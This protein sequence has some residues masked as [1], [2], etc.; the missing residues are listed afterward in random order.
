MAWA[1]VTG[2]PEEWA[3]GDDDLL[4]SLGCGQP[5]Q[6][7]KRTEEG[8]ACGEDADTRYSGADFAPG[9]QRCAEA[10]T[11]VTGVDLGGDLVCAAPEPDLGDLPG[12]LDGVED[13]LD[14]L[15][16]I[17]CDGRDCGEDGCGGSCGDCAAWEECRGGR[18]EPAVAVRQGWVLVPPGT[19]TMGSP[20]GEPGRDEDETQHQ[21]T[22]TRAF[23]LK[24]TEVTQGEWRALMGGN[25]S[26]FSACGDRCP[27]EQ[28]SRADAAGFCNAL[29]RAHGLEE[30]YQVDGDDIGWPDGLDCEGYRLPT[31]AEWEYA[32]RAGAEGAVPGE[33]P[34]VI[35][36]EAHAEA[37]HPLGWYAGNS[38]VTHA[39]GEDCS[40]WAET[41]HPATSCGTHPVALK[42]PNAWGLYDVVGNVWEWVWDL[43][44]PYAGDAV[45]PTGPGVG[46][47]CTR[48]GSW[49]TLADRCR[50][51]ARGRADT[52]TIWN[53][54]GLRPARTVP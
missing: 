16:A 51:A 18:C 47:G 32:A 34:F 9:G 13:D 35:V 7:P 17:A 40:D 38:G 37:L 2:V 27:V 52:R 30:C 39:G 12:R 3:D 20:D 14:G 5:G 1:G 4:A 26:R 21:V 8:W 23:L 15:C 28:V 48:G 11:F 19:F 29:S 49:S 42:R 50:S 44:A 41:Q 45:D 54:L 31:E 53:A 43:Q 33:R 10:G 36:G 24:A 6:V 25:P 46:S 22:L